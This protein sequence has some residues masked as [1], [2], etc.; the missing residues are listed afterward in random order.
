MHH[1]LLTLL[2][3]LLLPFGAVAC[4]DTGEGLQQDVEDIESEVEEEIQEELDETE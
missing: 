4:D 2:V 1:R 3:A